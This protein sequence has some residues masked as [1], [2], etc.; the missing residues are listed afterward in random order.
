[1][2]SSYE[3]AFWLLKNGKKKDERLDRAMAIDDNKLPLGLSSTNG[4]NQGAD[5]TLQGAFMHPIS[6]SASF[7]TVPGRV[8]H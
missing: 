4:K 3:E 5:G 8:G 2:A 7:L 1:M 6:A